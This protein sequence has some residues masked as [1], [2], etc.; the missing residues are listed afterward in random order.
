MT[1]HLNLAISTLVNAALALLK[2]LHLD[3]PN[4]VAIALSPLFIAASGATMVLVARYFPLV[5]HTL[6]GAD[7]T[8]LFTAG[9]TYAVS[10]LLKWLHGWQ[11]HEKATRPAP[12]KV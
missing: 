2:L 10:L 9:G 1:S 4:R 12:A 7:V 8:I 3:S 5:G 6:S 11:A